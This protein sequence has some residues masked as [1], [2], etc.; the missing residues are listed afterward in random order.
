MEDVEF[1]LAVVCGDYRPDIVLEC[2][3]GVVWATRDF[4]ESGFL[5]QSDFVGMQEV[6]GLEIT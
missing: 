6:L 5:L 2:V 4:L 3:P 1:V